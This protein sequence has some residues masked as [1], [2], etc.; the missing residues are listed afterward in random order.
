MRLSAILSNCDLSLTV[1]TFE[2]DM[3]PQYFRELAQ[4]VREIAARADPFT[5]KRL[6]T[7]AERYDA[8]AL[9]SSRPLRP[10]PLPA[11]RDD[12]SEPDQSE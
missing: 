2:R 5:K 4:R 10:I 7:L 9:E 3:E 8:R 1:S 11:G 6:F 12:L